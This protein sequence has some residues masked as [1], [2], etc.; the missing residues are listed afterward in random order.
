MTSWRK[1]DFPKSKTPQTLT[2]EVQ[3]WAD[4]RVGLKSGADNDVLN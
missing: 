3:G 4:N 2:D 1:F